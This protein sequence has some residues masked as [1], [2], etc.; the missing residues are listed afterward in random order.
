MN[1]GVSSIMKH[2]YILCFNTCILIRNNIAFSKCSKNNYDDHILSKAQ[3]A[4]ELC[5]SIEYYFQNNN[6]LLEQH[7][8]VFFY[9]L[10][11]RYS[12]GVNPIGKAT[13]CSGVMCPKDTLQLTNTMGS[14][15]AGA[16]FYSYTFTPLLDTAFAIKFNVVN[17]KSYTRGNKGGNI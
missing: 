10:F 8:N 5:A 16:Y 13:N 9:K 6:H 2:Q 7:Q 12:F 1:I 4:L 17:R 15:A 11:S 14:L 3:F